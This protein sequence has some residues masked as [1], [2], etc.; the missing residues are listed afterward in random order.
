[1]TMRA[2]RHSVE[3]SGD[4]EQTV[5]SHLLLDRPCRR[6]TSRE[7]VMIRKRVAASI[8][9]GTV[10]GVRMSTKRLAALAAGSTAAAAALAGVATTI[11]APANAAPKYSAITYS[12]KTGAWGWAMLAG[13]QQQAED[14]AMTYCA[15]AGGT[16]CR[17]MAASVSGG[18]VA[19]A[20]SATTAAG[21]AGP[22]PAEAQGNAYGKIGGG[23]MLVSTCSGTDGEPVDPKGAGGVSPLPAAPPAQ[24]AQ[25]APA[26]EPAPTQPVTD[27]ISM[28]FGPPGLG[29][30]TA[31]ISNSS[32]LNGKC[33]YDATPFN[34]HRDFNVPAHGSTPLTFNGL[35]TGTSY[36]VTVSCKDA[37]GKQT[38][39]IG[40]TTQDVSF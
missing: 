35:N 26:A 31:T 12:P 3:P 34:T 13:S 11:A 9:F 29:N 18:C 24:P 20:R 22:T 23:D 4:T 7:T 19:L 21:G 37:S 10:K 30:I 2:S 39:P 5:A 36:H 6:G 14:V 8:A 32:D 15:G 1:M 16:D 33:T 25:P 40:T 27:A 28:S 17:T 38:Q